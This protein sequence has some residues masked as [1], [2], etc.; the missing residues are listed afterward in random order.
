MNEIYS[1]KEDSKIN[2]GDIIIRIGLS[3]LLGGLIGFQRELSRNSAGF[4]THILV[5]L[6]A[7]IAMITNEFLYY[8]FPDA[9]LDVARMGS[10]VI[11]GIGFLGAGSIIKDGF[12]VRGL[13]TA[14]GLWVVACLGIAV[15]AGFYKAAL[16]GGFTVV[17]VL[18]VLKLLE[19]KLVHKRNRTEIELRIKNA[20]GQLANALSILG[21]AGLLIKDLDIKSDD[22][23]IEA[24]IYTTVPNKL[25][26][27][28][29]KDAL[30]KD[31]N[32]IVESIDLLK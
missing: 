19:G 26:L 6:G 1:A 16:I 31:E 5:C 2:T 30:S 20:P 8:Q 23:W 4:R 15:G 14:A 7:C 25:T 24:V 21:N 17:I 32:I 18:A 13:T 12:R 10:Y 9:Q 11:S 3:T 29:L 28:Q 22:E 27:L